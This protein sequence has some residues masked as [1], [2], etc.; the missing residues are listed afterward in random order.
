[1]SLGCDPLWGQIQQTGQLAGREVRYAVAVASTNALALEGA[2]AGV[3]SGTV[4]VAESQTAGRGRLGK[5]WLSPAG[6]GLYATVLLRPRLPLGELSRLTLAAGLA[7]ARAIDQ[8]SGLVSRI[9]WPNDVLLEGKKV[10]GVLAECD[11]SAAEPAVVLGVGVN[12]S[13]P[14]QQLPPELQGRATSLLLASGKEIDRGRLL[15]VLLR[16]IDQAVILLEGDDFTEILS[17]WKTKD[18]TAHQRITW[19]TTEGR[20]VCGV[21]LGP[22]PQGLLVIRDGEGQLHHVLSGDLT[23]DPNRLNGYVPATR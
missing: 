11:L 20:A 6:T 23:L 15:E 16:E 14:R 8:V 19:L 4:W 18:A 1:M 2:R 13:T 22:D 17:E 7:T 3:A 12:V 9:K 21:S 10:A 5:D